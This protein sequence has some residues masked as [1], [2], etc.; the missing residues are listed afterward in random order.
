MKQGLGVKLAQCS[1]SAAIV[2]WNMPIFSITPP[3]P[4]FRN[5][6]FQR[7][8]R[9]IPPAKLVICVP[10]GEPGKRRGQ[11]MSITKRTSCADPLGQVGRAWSLRSWRTEWVWFQNIHNVFH[12][13]LLETYER[14]ARALFTELILHG[15]G[16]EVNELSLDEDLKPLKST[17]VW[18]VEME[19]MGCWL[20]IAI[21]SEQV[22]IDVS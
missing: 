20:P 12:C 15:V 4:I 10:G 13:W 19:I 8:K 1:A 2:Y 9:A 17:L 7:K 5:D 22:H 16:F 6:A 11:L 21:G 18:Y 14:R 3:G